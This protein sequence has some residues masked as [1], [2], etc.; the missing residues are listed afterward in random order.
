MRRMAACLSS[1][2]SLSLALSALGQQSPFLPA[3]TYDK[4]TNE[5]SGDIAFEN[6]RSLVNNHVPTG[7][8][9]GF[10]DEAQ[11]VEARAK[12]Y[13]LEAKLIPLPAWR[14]S[15]G[16]PDQNWAVLG[17]E[18]WL[19]EPR[20]IKL[21]D[22]RETRFSVADNSPSA[23]ITAELI[24]VGEG[25]EESD[26]TGKGIQGKVV[27]AYGAANRVKE[28]A[29][30]ARGAVGIVSYNSSRTGPWTDHPDQI[31]WSRLTVSK[32]GEKSAPPVF[33]I[34][35]RAGLALSRQISGRGPTH[36]FGDSRASSPPLFKVH[37]KIEAAVAKPG[38]Q[39]LVEGIIRGT[40][41]H[42]QAIV[43]T[44]NLQEGYPFANDDRS[45]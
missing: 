35:P 30:W 26:Y 40:T 13:G 23:D 25:S 5:I 14:N 3:D 6:L 10:L 41:V 44:A 28:L 42:D 21:G 29:C 15:P 7:Q 22:V 16:E 27:L 11:W 20:V 39:G 37:L 19:V 38:R 34:S 33:V 17:G 1:L 2:V 8:P 31:A 12:S 43:L 4:L 36:I 24:D 45:G 32:E 9:H 18:L